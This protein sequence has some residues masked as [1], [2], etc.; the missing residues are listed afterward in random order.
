MMQIIILH[1]QKISIDVFR[2]ATVNIS[3]ENGAGPIFQ[4]ENKYV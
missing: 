3:E 4:F 1:T 2:S